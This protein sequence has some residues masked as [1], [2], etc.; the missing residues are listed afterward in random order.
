MSI[1]DELEK[2]DKLRASGAL[3]EAE[4]YQA[5]Q[6]V[7][8]GTRPAPSAE[9]AT[10]P[11]AEPN[12]LKR[13]RRSSRDCVI[14]GVCGGLAKLVPAIPSWVWRIGFFVAILGYGTGLLVYVLLW[15]FVPADDA[16]PAA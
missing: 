3:T 10:N 13:F 16:D 12:P 2:L 1:A 9:T 14:G 15:I 4:Y 5:K 6:R 11:P 8:D 7:L